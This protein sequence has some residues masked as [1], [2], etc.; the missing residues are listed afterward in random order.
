MTALWRRTEPL[1]WGKVTTTKMFVKESFLERK[2]KPAHGR[3][4]A[5][6]LYTE[7]NGCLPRRLGILLA[8][9]NVFLYR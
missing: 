4:R 7:V 1:C 8:P 2:R 9:R 6:V 3:E 5:N